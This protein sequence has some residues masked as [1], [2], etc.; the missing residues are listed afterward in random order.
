MKKYWKSETTH[1][2]AA[3]FLCLFIMIMMAGCKSNGTKET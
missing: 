3:V 1:G 2:I